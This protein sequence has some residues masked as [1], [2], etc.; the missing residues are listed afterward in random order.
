[1][2][3][4]ADSII[5]IITVLTGHGHQSWSWEENQNYQLSMLLYADHFDDSA[6]YIYLAPLELVIH[7]ILI[8]KYQLWV[9]G[10][11]FSYFVIY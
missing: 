10:H 5:I 3:S 6:Y 11:L 4:S 9:W 1:M 2:Q 8:I 7:F